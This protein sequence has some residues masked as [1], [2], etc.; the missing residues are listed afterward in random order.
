[1]ADVIQAYADTHDSTKPTP[2]LIKQILTSTADDIGAPADEQG[3]GQLN[4]YRAVRAAQQEPGS[5]KAVQHAASDAPSLVTS[6]TQLDITADSG[7]SSQSVTLYNASKVPTVVTGTYRSLGTATQIGPTV[8]EPV[9]APDPSLP[10]PAEGAQAA[11]PITFTVPAGLDRLSADMIIPDPTNSTILSFTLVD[12][13]GKL[14]QISYD[15]GTGPTH[16][17]ATG[18]VS[19]IQHVEIAAPTKGKW[20]AKILWANGRSHLQEA[21]NVPGSFTGNISFRITGQHYVTTSASKA[22]AIPAH[23]SVTVP[24]KIKL[25]ATAGDH[26]E[27]VQFVGSNGAQTSLAV[28]RRTVLPTGGGTFKT[29]ITSSVGR[30]IGQ[31]STYNLDVPAGK[32]DLDV[33]FHTPDAS[34]DNKFTFYLINP[35]G[36]VVA[37]DATPTTTLQGIGS[38]KPLADAALVTPNPVAGRWEVDVELNLTSSGKEFT[39]T[40]TGTVGYDES[41]VTGFNLPTS[42][43]TTIAFGANRAISVG[44]TNTTGVGRSFSLASAAGDL[45]GGAVATPVYLAAGT[46]ALLIATLSPKAAVGMVVQGVLSVI[47]NTSSINRTQQIA[48]LPYTYT[49]GSAVGT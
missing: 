1:V 2:A 13:N 15:Y 22:V 14:A 21:P 4:V 43:G 16:P 33:N 24:L 11:T 40:V 34:P 38:D 20:T 5:S 46:T 8:T 17:G 9:S 7:I 3:A 36:T 19:N 48:A 47:S 26:P 31:I 28:A 37:Q 49:V 41:K 39:Q 18:T 30:G 10:V 12:P 23:S 32:R 27:S 44:V 35:S 42:A 6:P 25:P 29:L 45:S